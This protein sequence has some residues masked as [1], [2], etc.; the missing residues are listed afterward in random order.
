MAC[1]RTHRA[2]WS[3]SGYGL[4]PRLVTDKMAQAINLSTDERAIYDQTVRQEN[5][6]FMA[7]L[8]GLY[9][10]LVGG[11]AGDNLDTH[12]L[13][14]EILQKSPSADVEAARKRLAEE[15]AGLV[16]PPANS[17]NRS[18]VE[19]M[20]RLEITAGSSLEQLLAAELDP[21]K[22]HQIRT[23]GWAGGDDNILSGCPD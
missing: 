19:R 2:R 23:S 8:R 15:R 22:A 7:A 12:A 6:R 3:K 14:M 13:F 9:Q 17:A 18:V 5:D 11:D 20:F 1:L 4:E 10:E 21:D 16:A